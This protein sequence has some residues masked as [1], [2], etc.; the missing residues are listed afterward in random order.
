MRRE[1]HSLG[2]LSSR[3]TLELVIREVPGEVATVRVWLWGL[4]GT[5]QHLLDTGEAARLDANSCLRLEAR[6][7]FDVEIEVEVEGYYIAVCTDAHAR[8]G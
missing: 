8:L 2:M 1:R 4:V 5:H 7:E 6:A 3:Q